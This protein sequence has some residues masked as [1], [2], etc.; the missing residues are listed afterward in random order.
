[1]EE[2]PTRLFMPSHWTG[3][4]D[5]S[6]VELSKQDR[7]NAPTPYCL[8]R[9][10]RAKT[11]MEPFDIHSLSILFGSCKTGIGNESHPERC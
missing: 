5:Y 7:S 9:G 1:M 3:E 6:E 8:C 10:R 11:P 4:T 2:N